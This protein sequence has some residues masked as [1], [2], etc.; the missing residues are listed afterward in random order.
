MS[1]HRLLLTAGI[2]ML[3]LFITV[4][5]GQA[6]GFYDGRN[7]RMIV[8]FFPGG[9][10]DVYSRLI[11]RHL[12]RYIPGRRSVIVQNNTTTVPRIYVVADDGSLNLAYCWQA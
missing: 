7:L 3:A 1:K 10:F 5:P 6:Q 12:P 2:S 11:A 8:S 9:G 4:H